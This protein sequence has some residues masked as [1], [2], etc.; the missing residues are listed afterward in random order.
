MRA[1]GVESSVVFPPNL[2]L[3]MVCVESAESKCIM[4]PPVANTNMIAG[5]C[6]HRSVRCT[7]HQRDRPRLR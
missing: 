7:S 6:L 5:I 1:N 2:P 3:I 4:R